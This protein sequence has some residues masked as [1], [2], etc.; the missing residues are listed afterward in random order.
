MGVGWGGEGG[1]RVKSKVK[2]DTYRCVEEEEEGEDEW[3]GN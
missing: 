1:R 2:E 3:M